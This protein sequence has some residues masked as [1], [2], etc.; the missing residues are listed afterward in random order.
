MNIALERLV[1]S[2][3]DPHIS[4]EI[5]GDLTESAARGRSRLWLDVASVCARRWRYRHVAP[6]AAIVMALLVILA[7]PRL[8]SRQVTA[9]DDAGSFALEFRGSRVTGVRMNGIPVAA[10][11]LRRSNHQLVIK[12]GNGDNDLVIHLGKGTSFTWAGRSAGLPGPD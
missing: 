11:R 9:T 2:M 7:A 3:V 10:A 6:H 12:G 8:R 5:L 1:S 4:E